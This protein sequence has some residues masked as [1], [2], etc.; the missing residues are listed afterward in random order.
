MGNA[1]GDKDDDTAVGEAVRSEIVLA[2]GAVVAVQRAAAY[3]YQER[4]QMEDVKWLERAIHGGYKVR[5]TG[6]NRVWGWLKISQVAAR[7]SRT[8]AKYRDTFYE[9]RLNV[10]RCRYLAAMK[11]NGI[12]RQ[13][14]LDKAKQS[15]ESFKQ[16]Y[17]ELGGE[18]W[19]GQFEALLKQ[20]EEA[21][22]RES[23]RD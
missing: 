23:N 21:G 5:S 18:Q 2:W 17:P 14:D 16:L 3:A 10:S 7:A 15:I 6:E 8:D 11:K 9:A 19:R 22:Q 4:G 20:I 13:Q 1:V 12:A